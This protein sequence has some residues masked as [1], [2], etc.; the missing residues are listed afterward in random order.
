M[1]SPKQFLLCAILFIWNCTFLFSQQSATNSSKPELVLPLGHIDPIVSCEFSP[2]GK[3]V[4]TGAEDHTAKIWDVVSG[5]ILKSFNGHTTTVTHARFSPDGKTILTSSYD[6]TVKTWDVQSGKLLLNL[7]GAEKFNDALFSPDGKRF[8]TSSED[9][10]LKIWD[11]KSGLLIIELEVTEDW[12]TQPKFSPDGKIVLALSH[13]LVNLWDSQTGKL[14]RTLKGHFSTIYDAEFSPDGKRI[15]TTSDDNKAK[16][17]DVESGKVLLTLEKHQETVYTGKF[18]PDGKK[19][20][21]ASRDESVIVWDALNGK[22]LMQ[23]NPLSGNWITAD[24]SPDGNTIITKASLFE[25]KTWDAVT[26]R[27]R[28]TFSL[29]NEGLAAFSPD[30]KKLVTAASDHTGSIWNVAE[31]KIVTKLKGHTFSIWDCVL[32]KDGHKMITTYWG[33]AAQVWDLT[34]GKFVSNIGTDTNIF[35]GMIFTLDG[36]SIITTS[37]DNDV[38]LWDVATGKL[39]RK[40]SG[41]SNRTRGIKLNSSGTIILSFATDNTARTWDLKTGK[42][43]HVFE[44]HEESIEY[45]EFSRDDK[46][47]LTMSQDNTVKIW[48]VESGK[49]IHTLKEHNRFCFAA[50]FSP[51]GKHIVTS[52]EDSLASVWDV[53][54][55]KKLF[56][57]YEPNFGWIS[58]IE[59]NAVGDEVVLNSLDTVATVW[60]LSNGKLLQRLP[61]ISDFAELFPNEKNRL[62]FAKDNAIMIGDLQT[63]TVK[64]TINFSGLFKFIDWQNH[65]LAT[66][67]NSL[68]TF[69]DTESGLELYSMA[70]VDAKEY[71]WVLP[72]GEYMTTPDAAKHLAW[73]NNFQLYDFDQW[74]LQYNRP[75]KVLIAL[76]NT[77][78]LLTKSYYEAYYKRLRKMGIDSTMFN[79]DFHVPETEITNAE[80]IHDNTNQSSVN[81]TIRVSDSNPQNFIRKI[82]VTVNGNPIYGMKGMNVEATKQNQISLTIPITLSNGVNSIKVSC[83]NNHAAASIKQTAYINYQPK[84]KIVSK[85]YYIGIGVS[86]YQNPNYKLNYAAKD[87]NDLS[88]GIKKKYPDA[89]IHLLTNK[90]ATRE[91]IKALKKDI[92][93]KTNVDDIVIVSFSG[94]GVADKKNN[95]YFGTYDISFDDPAKRGLSYDDIEWLLDSI[96]ARKKLVMMDACHSGELDKE[97]F[98]EIKKDSSNLSNNNVVASRG[99]YMVASDHPKLGMKNSFTLMQ[100]LFANVSAGN[101]ATIISA[102][103]GTEFAFEGNDWKN[104][105]FTYC[106]LQGLINRKADANADS[107]ITVNELKSFVG[108]EVQKL[109]NG[110]QKP[111]ARQENLE[112]DW[113]IW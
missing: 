45:A 53:Q 88:K 56:S 27:L 70:A 17:W 98:Y 8:I 35:Y 59:F 108:E 72:S 18:S 13:D 28:H 105:V 81:L 85:T 5:R 19:I 57:L 67:D 77:D 6:N 68:L 66:T 15:V 74:D 4:L 23:I 113:R 48:D 100:D 60:D 30:G 10:N 79:G 46:S 69:Y 103:A 104:G 86:D 62:T 51:D 33:K 37:D 20:I 55:G 43:L 47:I 96:P 73:E 94:H 109:T 110:K 58:A 32:S 84:E 25:I 3:T 80:A 99:V 49:L 16:T 42:S 2:D 112:Y 106:V 91:N 65:R 101:G 64:H 87:V 11:S 29:S 38:C 1:I 63:S 36:K 21:T 26:G 12:G 9:A 22:T 92:L 78:T 71:V 40:F 76:G 54:S 83:L 7:I 14:I 107:E 41:H 82:M 97:D 95:F 34:N 44:G 39:I 93:S 102:A 24:F 52:A 111:T 90:D 50:R 31:G 89:E 61:G 75:D